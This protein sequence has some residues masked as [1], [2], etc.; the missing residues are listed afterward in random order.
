MSSQNLT[1]MVR[2]FRHGNRIVVTNPVD[3]AIKTTMV[4]VTFVEIGRRGANH[5]VSDTSA[6]LDRLI[7]DEL[8]EM[9]LETSGLDQFR[10]HTQPVRAEVVERSFP[11]GRQFDAWINR[12]LYSVPQLRQQQVNT[13]TG[14]PIRPRMIDGKPTF[15]LTNMEETPKDDVDARLSNDVLAAIHPEYFSGEI[16]SQTAPVDVLERPS[17]EDQQ[18]EMNASMGNR[19]LAGL[20]AD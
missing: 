8:R 17:P 20:R 2:V 18:A 3:P 10:I 15:F 14:E 13:L 6:L 12:S 1:R 7:A 4:N 19:P 5:Q 16:V 9:G 11:V